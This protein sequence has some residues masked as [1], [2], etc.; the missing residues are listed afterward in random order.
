[1]SLRNFSSSV[2]LLSCFALSIAQSWVTGTLL[3]TA[4]NFKLRHYRMETS[5]WSLLIA[6]FPIDELLTATL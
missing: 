1:M 6:G 3:S 4:S 2:T 5:E